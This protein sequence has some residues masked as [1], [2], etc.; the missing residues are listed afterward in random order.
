MSSAPTIEGYLPEDI[1]PLVVFL[2]SDEAADISG[3]TFYI[4]RTEVSL[5]SEPTRIKT[6]FSDD[7]WTVDQLANAVPMMMADC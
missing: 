3:R 7:G 4:C 2:A 1:A 5:Y 6:V